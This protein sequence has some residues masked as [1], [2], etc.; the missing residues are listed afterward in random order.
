MGGVRFESPAAPGKRCAADRQLGSC[1]VGVPSP[2]IFDVMSI[3]HPNSASRGSLN[4]FPR[5]FHVNSTY[6]LLTEFR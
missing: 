6:G 3:P 4:Q 1:P 2:L 5:K